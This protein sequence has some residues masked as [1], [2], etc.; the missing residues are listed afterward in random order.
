MRKKKYTNTSPNYKLWPQIIHKS[1]YNLFVL[2]ILFIQHYALYQMYTH[3]KPIMNTN[4]HSSLILDIKRYIRSRS[5]YN[6][7]T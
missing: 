4:I 6:E 1:F 2:M 5:T 3:N 7:M